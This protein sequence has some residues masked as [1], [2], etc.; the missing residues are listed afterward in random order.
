MKHP[1]NFATAAYLVLLVVWLS[2]VATVIYV[3]AHFA[4]KHW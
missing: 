1:F 2:F 4:I 3:I